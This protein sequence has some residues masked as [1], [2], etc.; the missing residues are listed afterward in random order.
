[1]QIL[2][3]NKINIQAYADDMVL[4]SPTIQGLQFLIN[5]IYLI[6]IDLV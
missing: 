5:E 3:L 4:L 6:L 1:M 2:G